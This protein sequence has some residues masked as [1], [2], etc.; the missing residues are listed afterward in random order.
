MIDHPNSK[1]INPSIKNIYSIEQLL[2]SYLVA[3]AIIEIREERKLTLNDLA[4]KHI[5]DLEVNHPILDKLYR[6]FAKLVGYRYPF[7][8]MAK[9]G[10]EDMIK[11][12]FEKSPSVVTAASNDTA[13]LNSAFGANYSI[14]A[15]V[16]LFDHTLNVFNHGLDIGE[17]KGRIMQ[18]AIPILGCLFH[19]FGKSEALRSEL[20]GNGVGKVYKAHAEVSSMYIKEVMSTKYHKLLNEQPTETIDMLANAVSNHHP[21]QNREKGD[22]TIGFIIE[23]DNRAR[24]EEFKRLQIELKK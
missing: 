6:D 8:Y 20:V 3:D 11:Y 12:Q 5:P 10:F 23:A 24:K 2:S 15:K 16:N 14:L 21:K 17:S 4:K 19:D 13:H 7:V 18:I 22:T 1:I 9:I